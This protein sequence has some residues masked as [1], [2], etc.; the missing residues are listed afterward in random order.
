LVAAKFLAPDIVLNANGIEIRDRGA[1]IDRI[2]GHWA[3][4]PV[5]AQGEW[6]LPENLG[7]SVPSKRRISRLG[8]CTARLFSDVLF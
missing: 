7:E 8:R 2:T 6:S 5:L 3:F 1:V 4:T